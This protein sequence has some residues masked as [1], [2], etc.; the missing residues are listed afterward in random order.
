MACYVLFC[1]GLKQDGKQESQK[2]GT[3]IFDEV[4]VISCLMWNSRSHKII[5][6][7]MSH[8]ELS[9]LADIYQVLSDDA[10][11]EQTSY[12]LQFLWRD[13]TSSFDIVGKYFTCYETLKSKFVLS[14]VLETVK[15]FKL[16][17]LDTLVIMCDG[18]STILAAIKAT[19]GQF[20]VY[21]MDDSKF[22]T[23]SYYNVSF[24]IGQSDPYEVKPVMINPFN[25]LQP[26]CWLI[27]PTHQVMLIMCCD[28]DYFNLI[29]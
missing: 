16:H 19:H 6:L 21:G 17:G 2:V 26:I 4:K 14:C 27:R 5:G 1:E 25:P 24:C 18:A 11:I 22:G 9:S 3:L 10:T 28:F 7:S 13:L 12:I 20:G 29:A 8:E 15:L 23:F